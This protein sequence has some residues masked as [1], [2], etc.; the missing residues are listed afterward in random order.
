MNFFNNI[1]TKIRNLFATGDDV[2]FDGSD[3]RMSSAAAEEARRVTTQVV[4]GSLSEMLY[5]DQQYVVAFKARRRQADELISFANDY[6]IDIDADGLRT[7]VL[8]DET[9]QLVLNQVAER[10]REQ[11]RQSDDT[12]Y[13]LKGVPGALSTLNEVRRFDGTGVEF[14]D[15]FKYT[16]S[17]TEIAGLVEHLLD[18]GRK[19][20]RDKGTSALTRWQAAYAATTRGRV[21]QESGFV[22]PTADPQVVLDRLMNLSRDLDRIPDMILGAVHSNAVR[23]LFETVNDAVER[24]QRLVAQR[25]EEQREKQRQEAAKQRADELVDAIV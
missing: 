15:Y 3:R 11:A 18:N 22:R 13:V 9:G 20:P 4:E 10:L 1:T 21:C 12:F 19:A 17:A 6:G 25:R 24:E 16:L 2:M 23:D 7:A 5:D 8:S 14:G